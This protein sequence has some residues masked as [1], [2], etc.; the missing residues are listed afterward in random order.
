MERLG[1]FWA[2]A[3]DLDHLEQTG[4]NGG[5]QFV[6]I[7]QLAGGGEQGDFFLER[8]A[9]ALDVT[10]TIIGDELV[11]RFSEPLQSAGGVGVG[12]AFE[13]I[14]ALQIEQDANLGKDFGN[15][16]FVHELNMKFDEESSS[17]KAERFASLTSRLTELYTVSM[18]KKSILPVALTI[19]GSDSGGGAGIQADLKTFAALGVHGTSAITCVTAQNPKRVLGIEPCAPAMVRK[20]MEAVFAELPPGAVK[21]GMLHSAAIVRVVAEF[22]RQSRNI[23]LVVDPVMVATS[24]RRLLEPAGVKVL[25]EK[26]LPLAALVT[27]NLDEVAVLTGRLPGNVEEM[28]LAAREIQRRF[29]CAALVKGGHLPGM[30]EA[31]DIFYDGESELLLSG[32][33]VRGVRTHGT[34]CTY[35]AAIVAYLAL[36]SDL[37]TAV[38]KAKRHISKAIAKNKRAGKHRDFEQFLFL[39]Y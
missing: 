30:K 25:C 24:G 5:F 1:F 13:G 33:L 3:G 32:P 2:D 9:D 15:L 38:R 8:F 34:G 18:S 4:G 19:A 10:E 6:V 31:V 22:F 23:A 20:Q 35:S 7:R 27:P 12:A 16:V 11:E 21:T 36:G 29:G 37:A 17:G 26:L 39:T 28:R 14:F